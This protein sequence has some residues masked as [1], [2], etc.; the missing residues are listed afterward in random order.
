MNLFSPENFPFLSRKMKAIFADKQK[1]FLLIMATLKLKTSSCKTSFLNSRINIAVMMCVSYLIICDCKPI[2]LLHQSLQ[3]IVCH[4]WVDGLKNE[5]KIPLEP[6]SRL[7][8][9]SWLNLTTFCKY[10][11]QKKIKKYIM[12]HNWRLTD[13]TE[14]LMKLSLLFVTRASL[15]FY[16]AVYHAIMQMFPIS[17]SSC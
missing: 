7:L 3:W 13:A 1:R 8:L 14:W 17:P 5:K 15:C 6:F 9:F 12:D 16:I 11:H 2:K 4:H 10:L